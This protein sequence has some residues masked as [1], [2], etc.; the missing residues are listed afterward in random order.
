MDAT[1]RPR[2]D[3]AAMCSVRWFRGLVVLAFLAS[4]SVASAVGEGLGWS[5]P[6]FLSA[7]GRTA[8]APSLGLLGTDVPVATWAESTPGGWF[9]VMSSK[10]IAGH[11]S[12]A[13]P[14]S[15]GPID[16]P[17]TF[18]FGPRMAVTAGGAYVA[19]WLVHRDQPKGDGTFVN[20]AVVEG[21]TGTVAPGAPPTYAPYFFAGRHP[22]NGFA[23]AYTPQVLMTGDG[24]GVVSY[25]YVN[26]CG[27]VFAGLT[28][29]A[30]AQPLG[31]PGDPQ[32][33]L[34]TLLADGGTNDDAN[35]VLPP[36]ATAGRSAGWD[37]PANET[38]AVVTTRAPFLTNPRKAELHVT[39]DPSSWPDDGTIL[40]LPGF[41]AQVAVMSSGQV[42][43]TAPSGD[44]KL[45][46]WRT[47]DG[48]ATPIDD[49][50][51]TVK[52]KAA[53]ATFSDNTATI[54]YMA[55]DP[56]N[57]VFRIRAVRLSGTGNV[58]EPV[59]LSGPDA[60][61]RNPAIAYAPD[62]TTHVV[63]SQG[64]G[65][66]G[67]EHGGVGTGVY[68][69]Y[70]L[71]DGEF[72]QP[73]TPVV[74]GV[75]AAHAPKI[76]V[77]KDGFA[78]VVAQIQTDAGWRIAA[79][80]HAN[81]AVPKSIT[82]PEIVVPDPLA[83]GSILTC[84]Q[85]TWTADPTSFAFQWFVDGA[86]LG[87]PTPDPTHVVAASDLTHPIVCRVTASNQAGS[88]TADSAPV[89]P[90]SSGP[91]DGGLVVDPNTTFDPSHTSATFS[92]TVSG[93]GTVTAGSPAAAPQILVP[94]VAT[95]ARKQPAK[96]APLLTPAT[97]RA[98]AAGVVQITVS[99][100]K[101][102]KKQFRKKRKKGL[103][104]PVRLAFTPDGGTESAQVVEQLFKKP[105]KNAR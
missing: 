71:P 41:G 13:E 30:G 31:T 78:T 6:D 38:L 103:A 9:P 33:S 65:G 49:D 26:C 80:V 29:I 44:G 11:W 15:A 55:D 46:L 62:G 8:L 88:G 50:I 52:N 61:A 7:E 22:P 25:P 23:Y 43:A 79:F 84:T 99:L 73:A 47:G 90:G 94:F 75:G 85:G 76:V 92:V 53:I 18:S 20:Q 34:D 5:A 51:G 48:A 10:P 45:L 87:P 91:G 3:F 67:N 82:P 97:V 72:L 105:K 95:P 93:P 74:D 35:P 60:V 32:T 100:S 56:D 4:A 21:A 36:V 104:V 40:P 98:E 16:A 1:I 102:G 57:G 101:A 64:A 81:P 77:A 2:L 69:T 54:A 96:D 17:S 37:T 68:A 24:H 83:V 89:T 66:I 39:E 86:A 63:W 27:G 42:I 14:L 12:E 59:T 19:A 58:S 28:A 70:R